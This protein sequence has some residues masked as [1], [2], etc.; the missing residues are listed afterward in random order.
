MMSFSFAAKYEHITFS[1]VPSVIV[2]NSIFVECTAD[3]GS[4]FYSELAID[5]FVSYCFFSLCKA[6]DASIGRGSAFLVRTGKIF[7]KFCC[8]DQ[9]V[10]GYGADMMAWSTSETQY[11]FIQS[12]NSLNGNH[13]LWVSAYSSS[14]FKFINITSSSCQ[15]SNGY[16]NAINIEVHDN[17]DSIS[18]FNLIGCSNT[19]SVFN[20]ELVDS[21]TFSVSNINMI[22]NKDYSSFFSFRKSGNS[23]AQIV[24]SNFRNNGVNNFLSFYGGTS[25]TIEISSC[26][27]DF[28]KPS[29]VS[30]GTII[31]DDCIFDQY[32]TIPVQKD[33]ICKFNFSNRCPHRYIT[34]YQTFFMIYIVGL[35]NIK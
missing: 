29:S 35:M 7:A 33:V 18:F 13:A 14:H 15:N 4:G 19:L 5:H 20:F 8:A 3:K 30:S 22:E 34:S 21:K 2:S 1:S 17:P 6:S 23:N 11:D 16:G 25:C 9:C 32:S 31:S 26:S 24:D 10:S 12:F 27:F 28:T